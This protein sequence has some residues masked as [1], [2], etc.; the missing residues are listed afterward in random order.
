M[1]RTAKRV[2]PLALASCLAFAGRE[3]DTV[4]RHAQQLMEAGRQA[5]RYDTFGD[6]AYWG[7]TLK[8]HQAIANVSPAA[9]LSVG[10][11]VDADALP[12][13]FVVVSRVAC[14]SS[15]TCSST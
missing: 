7:D 15:E 13:S 1:T 2:L 10:L 12:P 8:L 11:K 6:E 5:F 14:S 3:D 4:S 9:A